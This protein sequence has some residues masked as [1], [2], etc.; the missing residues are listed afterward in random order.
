MTGDLIMK[1]RY[2]HLLSDLLSWPLGS[3]LDLAH[4]RLTKGNQAALSSYGMIV[5]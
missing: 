5:T 4:S 1:L 2:P 3:S